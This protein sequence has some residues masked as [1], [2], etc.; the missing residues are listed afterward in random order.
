MTIPDGTFDGAGAL[1]QIENNQALVVPYAARVRLLA[2]R[3]GQDFDATIQVFDNLPLAQN[4]E[5][6]RILRAK[7][8]QFLALGRARLRLELPILVARHFN[9]LKT[10]DT[11]DMMKEIVVPFVDDCLAVITEVEGCFESDSMISR[12][13]S[14][15]AG[16]AKRRR[17]NGELVSLR[18]RI[19]DKCPFAETNDVRITLMILGRD[20]LIGTLAGSLALYFKQ[21]AGRQLSEEIFDS[22]PTRTGVPYIDRIMPDGKAVRCALSGLRG[23]QRSGFFGKGAHVCLGRAITTEIF[24]EVSQFLSHVDRCVDVRTYHL[25]KDDVFDIPEIFE[26]DLWTKK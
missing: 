4:G 25:R 20:A 11:L 7:T 19:E 10:S 5:R 13:F 24:S 21:V 17:L 18:Q 22:M 8:A 23:D 6:H 1:K 3:L 2:D 26:V 16:V 9:H 14:Q 12:V 15:S